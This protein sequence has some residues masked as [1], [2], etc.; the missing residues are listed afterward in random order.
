M[1]A[2]ADGDGVSRSE[3]ERR[4]RVRLAASRST[5]P[6]GPSQLGIFFEQ[7]AFPESTSYNVP[8][9]VGLHG[10]LVDAR[11]TVER[12][13]NAVVERQ[14]MLRSRVKVVSGIPMQ[15]IVPFTPT[16]L[17]EVRS[18][19]V[20]AGE[21]W[22]SAVRPL[23]TEQS[24][25]PFD[26]G[27][28]ALW[29]ASLVR[30]ADDLHVLLLTFHHL[31]VDGWSIGVFLADFTEAFIA[32]TDGRA[33]VL[34]PLSARYRDYAAAIASDN[35]TERRNEDYWAARLAGAQTTLDLPFD[36]HGEERVGAVYETVIPQAVVEALLSVARECGVTPFVALL[37]CYDLLLFR[38]TG[39]SDIVLLVSVSNR[40]STAHRGVIG[41]FAGV[42]PMRQR[43]DPRLSFRSLLQQVRS[44]C[45]PDLDHPQVPLW[46]IVERLRTAGSV[47]S[48]VPFQAG[49]DYQYTPWPR[50]AGNNLSVVNGD[51][52]SPKLEL[53]LS[54]SHADGSL[55]AAFEYDA[56]RLSEAM[57]RV[58][59]DEF[60]DIM[61]HGAGVGG[62]AVDRVVR[63]GPMARPDGDPAPR[64]LDAVL[65]RCAT[66][67]DA[68]AVQERDGAMTYG[69]LER[70]ARRY[71][72]AIDSVAAPGASVA[73][74]KQQVAHSVA[75]MLG[76]WWTGRPVVLLGEADLGM[77]DPAMLSTLGVGVV[78]GEAGRIPRDDADGIPMVT[79]EGLPPPI[80][81]GPVHGEAAYIVLT[82]GS[83]GRPKPVA[84][85]HGALAAYV[86]EAVGM[87]RVTATDRCSQ[88]ASLGFDTSL[89]ELLPALVTG[90]VVVPLDLSRLGS[91]PALA[92]ACRNDGITLL[93]L[94]TALWHELAA[95][96]SGTKLP[97]SVR[98]V[99]IGGEAANPSLV[100]RWLDGPGSRAALLNT[101]GPTETTVAVTSVDLAATKG[102][103]LRAHTP[104]GREHGAASCQVL[105]ADLRPVPVGARGELYIGG[106]AVT[107]GYL[108]DPS[109]TAGAF[110]P[111]PFS[112]HPGARMYRTGDVVRRRPD[113]D[114][115]FIGRVDRQTKI[116]G[117]RLEPGQ[118]ESV[119]AQHPAVQWAGV[120]IRGRGADLHLVAAVLPRGDGLDLGD[121]R[122]W[123]VDRLPEWARPR[124][125][126]PVQAV[127]RTSHG[128]V[129]QRWLDSLVPAMATSRGPRP[130][131]EDESV[132]G[133]IWSGLLGGR[134]VARDDDFFAIG[135][136]SL[137]LIRLIARVQTVFGVTLHLGDVLRRRTV[138]DMCA[139]IRDARGH[140]HATRDPIRR[141]PLRGHGQRDVLPQSSSQQALWALSLLDPDSSAYNC[142]DVFE[143]SADIDPERLQRAINEVTSSHEAF[144]TSFGEVGGRPV[145]R[146]D[147]QGSLR[148]RSID[149]T[150]HVHEAGAR[151]IDAM[152]LEDARL[153]FDL[154]EAPL[155]RCTLVK[156]AGEKDVLLFS[157]HHLITDA[158]SAAIFVDEVTRTYIGEPRVSLPRSIDYGDYA[159]WEQ[160]EAVAAAKSGKAAL[161]AERIQHLPRRLDFRVSTSDSSAVNSVRV[162]RWLGAD[163]ASTLRGLAVSQRVTPFIVVL[164]VMTVLLARMTGTVR[165][166]IGIP[167]S[168][169]RR[170]E[171][172]H[173]I[174]YFIHTL[175]VPVEYDGEISFEELLD[176]T[177]STMLFAQD[178]VDA[179]CHEIMRHVAVDAGDAVREL[180]NVT[181]AYESAPIGR[182]S[183]PPGDLA[184][185][186]A[187][188]AQD[189]KFDLS[190]SV[191]ESDDGLALEWESRAGAIALPGVM[192]IADGFEG[193]LMALLGN[194]D[195]ELRTLA[196]PG[197]V[198]QVR[199]EPLAPADEGVHIAVERMVRALPA[200]EAI[201]CGDISLTYRGFDSCA[202]R[203]SHLLM[204]AGVSRGDLVAVS[205]RRDEWLPIALL[206]VWKSGAAWVALDPQQPVERSRLILE[207]S[208]AKWVMTRGGALPEVPGTVSIDLAANDRAA[209]LAAMPDFA[210]AV[211][212]KGADL[213]YVLY[214]SGSTG[215]PKG[216]EIEHRNLLH[217]DAALWPE[218]SWLEADAGIRWAWNAS[219]SFDAS[220]QGLLVLRH[221]GTLHI[222]DETLRRDP[223]ELL[224]WA[225]ASGVQMMDVTPR[226]A[227]VLLHTGRQ[228][229]ALVVGGEPIDEPLWVALAT[230][231]RAVNVY[232]P[233]EAT[234]DA[235]L[236]RIEGRV[237]NIGR[238][239]SGVVAEIC[240]LHGFPVPDGIPGELYLG[241]G[242]VGRG[243]RGGSELDAARFV[244]D[245]RGRW[246]RTGDCVRRDDDDRLVY[247]HRMDDQVKIRGY[248]VE[249]GE[250]SAQL[251]MQPGISD[252]Y[253]IKHGDS[254]RAYVTV[255][256][257]KAEEA[258]MQALT[259][260]LPEYMVPN[261]VTVIDSMPLNVNGKLDRTRLPVPVL[262]ETREE[263]GRSAG[264]RFV[265]R[266]IIETFGGIKVP[267]DANLFSHGADSL[268][269]ALLAMRLS[270]ETGL[271]FAPAAAFRSPTARGV[272]RELVAVAGSGEVLDAIVD[273]VSS[274]STSPPSR[275]D[276]GLIGPNT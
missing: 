138:A 21:D 109:Q 89:E 206:A 243:Y 260:A 45:V 108:G 214:T 199:R 240:D 11:R 58:M 86:R 136:H 1:T 125:I 127:H 238:P 257:P 142:A 76:A 239:L 274:R 268:T 259:R 18:V 5:F 97:A 226:Q 275:D 10:P 261:G 134:P 16:P 49:F 23:S 68:P 218:L 231:A 26:V 273:G 24:A 178:N 106:D 42:L 177:R 137:L 224:A 80:A 204:S 147:K 169:R 123:A 241:G 210:P 54:I 249:P 131:A 72:A 94:P 236:A 258:A 85:G 122:R 67:P 152:V 246:Y 253:V 121:L 14:E 156:G 212:I 217:L 92:A 57:V 77:L 229:P 198:P 37:L 6:L 154:S 141:S 119:L 17:G 235:T 51:P 112:P 219:F 100:V 79:G 111:D 148:V 28:D 150:Q 8:L 71:A 35:E 83:T 162:G 36:V 116:R 19:R 250:V 209:Q 196:W 215:R 27:A 9:I 197:V 184:R 164:A 87:L 4:L 225:E 102:L 20:A 22:R 211:A 69:M 75:A 170:E 107:W 271:R 145:Q 48:R 53:N 159:D 56:S 32:T 227:A 88:V 3:L 91:L 195:A 192:R 38:Y 155:A 201:R 157:W 135:G 29:R 110:L 158:W 52:L 62:D 223:V 63:G 234:V 269:I 113:G 81:K 103:A 262:D 55:L 190:L 143:L 189:G 39:Q 90:A 149:L 34:P 166:C 41:P 168:L 208:G 70:L 95:D 50:Q 254:L 186:R 242:G 221:G 140:G 146:I 93:N 64:V 172:E 251:R 171:L 165:F 47:A 203:L 207:E 61:R 205:M 163:Q 84:N 13:V 15:S 65:V 160:S 118:V 115:E 179:P 181:L 153:P 183:A 98:A 129:D 248:R 66:S 228:L 173:I 120:S 126:V 194:P 247:L 191:V 101:F 96:G 222:M 264:E 74:A 99:V 244:V 25:A 176:A 175:P 40:E 182:S 213:A 114:L 2:A 59:A 180:F 73:L 133:A 232:G 43:I 267:P 220:L 132:L 30:V 256:V 12:C 139:A 230:K 174:G 161:W 105:D 270:R 255:T 60:L 252:A 185:P 44:Q 187:R 265:D 128:K 263:W 272:H 144:R 82:S 117:H 33:A 216:V 130:P 233:T 167:M 237:P 202:N 245:A 193:W 124:D 7:A 188:G 276:P 104:I 46:R 151:T 31:V 200:A 78:V 266:V